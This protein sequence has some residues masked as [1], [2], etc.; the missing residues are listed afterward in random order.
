MT[1]EREV[2]LQNVKHVP[3]MSKNLISG[4]LISKNRFTMT[5]EADKLM[6]RK[7]GVYSGKWYVKD[8]LVKMNVMTV[9]P[10]VVAPKV[11]TNK[12]EL[13]AYLVESF[14]I[15]HES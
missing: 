5:L 11:S 4:T 1:Y 9:F 10:K 8:G 14:N 12:K 3:D 6:I 2:T 15:W 13:V 7:N